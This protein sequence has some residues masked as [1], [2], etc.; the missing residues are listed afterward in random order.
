MDE[1]PP[2]LSLLRRILP[3]AL[4][5]IVDP[6][7]PLGRAR[8]GQSPESRWQ[9]LFAAL[10]NDHSSAAARIPDRR[11]LL[12]HQYRV[13]SGMLQSAAVCQHICLIGGRGEGK[14]FVARWFAAAMGYVRVESLFLFED[15][16]ARGHAHAVT[17]HVVALYG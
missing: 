8:A 5:D 2:A 12:P 17:L 9:G 10:E 16:T 4:V 6:D 3:G 11:M 14:T 13:L 1:H 15:M 7:S